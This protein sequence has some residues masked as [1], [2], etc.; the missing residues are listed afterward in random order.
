MKNLAAFILL[1]LAFLSLGQTVTVEENDQNINKIKRTG[2]ST[3][4]ELDEK[5]VSNLFKKELKEFGRVS[6]DGDVYLIE[7][8]NMPSITSSNVRVYG[9]TS[10]VGK[11]GTLVW[12]A[13]D[14]GDAFI[15]RSHPKYGALE[16]IL[17]DFGVKVYLEDINE[18]VE[19]AEKALEKSSKDYNKVSKEGEDLS[20]DLK[21]NA[22][23]KESLEKQLDKNADEKVR[24]EKDIAQ[25]KKDKA[26]SEQ[27]VEKMKKALEL[28]KNKVHQVK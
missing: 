5:Y 28:V 17:H 21:N 4:I 20:N 22:K 18:Q 3:I 27:E 9:K 24:L 19:D 7:T 16:K 2:L 11:K 1:H 14:M 26:A 13:V 8:A 15:T 12:I 6:K 10:K 25:N 23:E